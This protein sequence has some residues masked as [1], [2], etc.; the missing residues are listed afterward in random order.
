[1]AD[2]RV[3]FSDRTGRPFASVKNQKKS[4]A[5]RKH[6]K[7]RTIKRDKS[8]EVLADSGTVFPYQQAEATAA[9]SVDFTGPIFLREGVWKLP[10]GA[11]SKGGGPS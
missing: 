8:L 1:M 10:A 11:F 2:P 6:E 5:F 9:L 4:K 7:C 3:S